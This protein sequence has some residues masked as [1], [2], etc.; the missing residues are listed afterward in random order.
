M[1]VKRSRACVR[2]AS[3]R[4]VSDAGVITDGLPLADGEV[5]A[6]ISLEYT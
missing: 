5:G 6:T 3:E 4:A 2:Y 1:I